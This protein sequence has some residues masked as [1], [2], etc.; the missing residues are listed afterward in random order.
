[1]A[2]V[3]INVDWVGHNFGAAPQDDAIACVATGKTLVEVEQNIVDAIR[4]HLDGM[5]AHGESIPEEFQGDWQPEF[6]LT[7]RAQL[8]YTD[9]FITRKALSR[10]TGINEQQLSHYATGRKTP[11][12]D[13]RKRISDGILAISRHLAILF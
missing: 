8:R 6:V 9:N 11:R 7:T 3:K 13:T 2:T 5:Q 12:P 4:F 1:M 10:E